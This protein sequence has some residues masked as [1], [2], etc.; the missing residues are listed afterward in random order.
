MC[1]LDVYGVCGVWVPHPNR[2]RHTRWTP[3]RV[4]PRHDGPTL[5]LC[6]GL[7]KTKRVSRVVE[8][9]VLGSPTPPLSSPHRPSPHH[10]PPLPVRTSLRSSA[11][12]GLRLC[13]AETRGRSSS[14]GTLRSEGR[15]GAL[16]GVL[17]T[18][19]R[20]TV[21]ASDRVSGPGPPGRHGRRRTPGVRTDRPGDE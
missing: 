6:H 8:S 15:G 21:D 18:V 1:T 13:S 5:P 17:G 19:E 12:S 16:R 11:R 4:R 9:S 14:T 3:D 10:P 20:F 7:T 2:T